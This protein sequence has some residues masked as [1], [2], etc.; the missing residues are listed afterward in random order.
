MSASVSATTFGLDS[1]AAAR[2][3]TSSSPR[4]YVASPPVPR[5]PGECDHLLDV[6]RTRMLSPD[7]RP[8]F[9][10][11]LA[12]F[13]GAES[14]VWSRERREALREVLAADGAVAWGEALTSERILH[15]CRLPPAQPFSKSSVALWMSRPT[16][17]P[18]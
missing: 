5:T 7:A 16:P 1:A 11:Q 17:V 9:A 6:T 4:T 8:F 14:T 13:L 15:A 18:L 3:T 10:R 2:A 12:R